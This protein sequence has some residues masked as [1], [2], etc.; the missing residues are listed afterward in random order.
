MRRCG[1]RRRVL[2]RPVETKHEAAIK[3]VTMQGGVFGAVGDSLSFV[4]GLP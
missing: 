1:R 2:R 3:M 4:A